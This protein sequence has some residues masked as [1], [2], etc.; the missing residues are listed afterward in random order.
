MGGGMD[1]ESRRGSEQ[2]GGSSSH[3]GE[4]VTGACSSM[5]SGGNIVAWMGDGGEGEGM[6]DELGG[7]CRWEDGG[8]ATKICCA[9]TTNE[10]TN[11]RADSEVRKRNV[12]VAAEGTCR[13]AL[14]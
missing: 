1:K 11:E 2:A 9:V 5:G 12:K 8:K 6:G 7:S 13:T 3:K 14:A 10:R 4:G